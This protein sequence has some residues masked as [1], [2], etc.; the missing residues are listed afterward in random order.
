MSPSHMTFCDHTT[1]DIGY[2][3]FLAKAG[4]KICCTAITSSL[5]Y[6]QELQVDQLA[7]LAM[8]LTEEGTHLGRCCV[9]NHDSCNFCRIIHC[10]HINY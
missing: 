10:R 7:Q 1:L 8:R 6:K 9:S 5:R 3:H 2:K 4:K